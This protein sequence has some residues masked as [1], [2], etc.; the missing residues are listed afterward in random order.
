ME[1]RPTQRTEIHSC[2]RKFDFTTPNDSFGQ[3]YNLLALTNDSRDIN[4]NAD[5]N[6][7]LKIVELDKMLDNVIAEKEDSFF[8][9]R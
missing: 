3:E 1:N 6:N 2:Y 8:R 9:L 4:L 5:Y 7:S